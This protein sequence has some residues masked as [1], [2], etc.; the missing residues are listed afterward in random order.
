MPWCWGRQVIVGSERQNTGV[1]PLRRAITLDTF[2]RDDLIQGQLTEGAAA[3]TGFLW[4]SKRLK[5]AAC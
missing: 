4:P 2:G 3:M 1:S 5:N